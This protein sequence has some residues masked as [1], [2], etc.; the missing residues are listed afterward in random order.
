MPDSSFI[1]KHYLLSKVIGTFLAFGFALIYSRELGV[2][3][4]SIVAYIFVLSSLIWIGLTSGTT[5]TLRKLGI[6]S[7][8]QITAS[9]FSLILVES[10]I[11]IILFISGLL[12]FSTYKTQIPYPI[13]IFGVGY[14]LFSGLAMVLIE[15]LIACL[16][17]SWGGYLELSAVLFQ[18]VLYFLSLKLGI[19]STAVSLLASFTLSYMIIATIIIFLLGTNLHIKFEFKSP[20]DFWKLTKGSHSLGISLGMMDRVDKMLVAFFFPLGALAQ[21]AVMSSLISFFRFIPDAL[22]KFIISSRLHY[23]RDISKKPL[24]WTLI[25]IILSITAIFSTQFLILN[26]L[27]RDWLL[28]WTVTLAFILQELARGVFQL[29]G[30]YK[31]SVGLAR[32]S[33]NASLSLVISA[34]PLSI[35]FSRYLGIIGIPLGF[36]ASYA[37]ILFY[38]LWRKSNA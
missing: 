34:V 11:G 2:E 29:T 20:W 17:Y 31:I 27:G 28:P 16:K 8:R 36:V 6:T 38:F 15:L 14:F 32:S 37:G 33:H 7:Q 9:F 1:Q 5:L 30:N 12:V 21:Y 3:N 22:S 23:W 26:L 19:F 18:Y 24:L 4:R 10:I 25:L 35:L 13:I